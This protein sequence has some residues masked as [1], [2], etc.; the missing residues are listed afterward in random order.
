MLFEGLHKYIS[1]L[2]HLLKHTLDTLIIFLD[3]R[4]NLL[5]NLLI[6]SLGVLLNFSDSFYYF[7]LEDVNSLTNLLRRHFLFIDFVVNI[8]EVLVWEE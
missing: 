8:A 6:K 1:L 4:P 3:L 2:L 7:F 5:R